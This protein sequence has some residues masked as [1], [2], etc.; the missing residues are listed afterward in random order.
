MQ[1]ETNQEQRVSNNNTAITYSINGRKKQP[2]LDEQSLEENTKY[3]DIG[4]EID[5]WNERVGEHQKEEEMISE[6]MRG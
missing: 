4:S 3:Y 2:K 6:G 1:N 5:N